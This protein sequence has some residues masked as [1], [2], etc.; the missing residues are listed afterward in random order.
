MSCLDRAQALALLEAARGYRYEAWFVLALDSGMRPGEIHALHW[1]DVC[2]AE[3]WVFVRQ[4]LEHVR[5]RPPRLKPTKTTAGKRKILIAP[6]TV[7]ALKAHRE[8]M[9][10]EGQ[11]VTAGPVF[12]KSKGEGTMIGHDTFRRQVF[13]PLLRRAGLPAVPI[14]SLR[15][16]SATLLLAADV[17]LKVVSLRLGHRDVAITLRHYV[18]ALPSMQERA[19]AAMEN[20]L[21]PMVIPHGPTEGASELT[22]DQSDVD[23]RSE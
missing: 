13:T 19:A 23:V 1:P 3:S 21:N 12:T 10:L 4:S 8:R 22:Q 2:L 15:H 16:T 14:Y 7:E 20:I 17:N 6:R 18:H 9:R 5:G 11:D